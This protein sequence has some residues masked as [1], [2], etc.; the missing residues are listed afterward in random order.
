MPKWLEK[1]SVTSV[2]DPRTGEEPPVGVRVIKVSSIFILCLSIT[3][4]LVKPLHKKQL[5]QLV[6]W[7]DFLY[8]IQTVYDLFQTISGQQKPIC[9]PYGETRLGGG[10]SFAHFTSCSG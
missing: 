8:K 6:M 3:N 7:V 10:Y 2:R 4:E 1:H 5:C 9:S